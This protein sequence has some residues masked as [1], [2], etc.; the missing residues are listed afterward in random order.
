MSNGVGIQIAP[1]TGNGVSVAPEPERVAEPAEAKTESAPLSQANIS[2]LIT[3]SCLSL[4]PNLQPKTTNGGPTV[5]TQSSVSPQ[6]QLPAELGTG[7][8]TAYCGDQQQHIIN[9]VIGHFIDN[10]PAVRD[11]KDF[12][13]SSYR[14][15]DSSDIYIALRLPV[16][17]KLLDVNT[18]K[19]FRDILDLHGGEFISL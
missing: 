4:L 11:P 15:R 5:V 3:S 10:I 16:L 17:R 9:T 2:N 7:T 1:Q 18:R 14:T 12:I 8:G 6:S 13:R 19:A